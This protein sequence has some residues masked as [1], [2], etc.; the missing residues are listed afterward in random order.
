[1]GLVVRAGGKRGLWGGEG[2]V[3]GDVEWWKIWIK[4][5]VW[6]LIGCD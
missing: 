2:R 5:R 4:N 1:M 6:M 3:W